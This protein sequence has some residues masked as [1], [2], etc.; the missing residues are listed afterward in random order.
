[1]THLLPA[2]VE[3]PEKLG[4]A[5][6]WRVPPRLEG[7]V[8]WV[9]AMVGAFVIFG[10][11]LASRG[12]DP[13]SV[14]HHAW[15]S[16]FQ[17]SASIQQILIK[18]T[19]FGLAA[20]AV[21]V[22]ARAGLVNVGGEGQVLVGAIAA[23]G[24]G[25]ACDQRVH[26]IPVMIL[27]FLAAAAAGAAWAGIAA[28]LRQVVKVNEA[29]STLL[30]NYVA[31]DL[32]LYL[33]YQPWKDPHGSGQP[34]TRPLAHRARLPVY[35]HSVVN[36]GL[37]IAVI[38]AVVVW[39]L[40]NK[41]SWGFR[42]AVVGGNPE[43]ARRAGMPVGAL[44]CSAMLVGGALAGIAGMVH[45]SGVEYE[46]RPGL[47]TN[48]GY[49]GFLAS[50][51]ARHRPVPVLLASLTFAAITVAGDSFQIDSGLPSATV[52]ILTGLILVAVLGWTGSPRKA[53]A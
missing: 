3:E 19:P 9:A 45:F 47:T 11:V 37:T 5:T 52:N 29:I 27:M 6:E 32:L 18:A 24:V 26:G 50:W 17:E 21:V 46:L 31:L 30:L 48:I 4:G 28:L 22:P 51:L 2:P 43:A 42:L 16:T 33:I 41:T 8:R 20:L 12:S 38:A 35:A 10:A 1:M 44:V 36:I 25:L 15:V 14:L 34:A 7:L 49:I 23:A 53:R 13:I 39:L 40:L